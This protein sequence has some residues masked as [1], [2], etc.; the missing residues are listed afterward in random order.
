MKKQ[1]ILYKD[2]EGVVNAV[3]PD[4]VSTIEGSV[5]CLRLIHANSIDEAIMIYN[6]ESYGKTESIMT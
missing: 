6:I 4:M 3:Y 2:E 1:Y 5:S